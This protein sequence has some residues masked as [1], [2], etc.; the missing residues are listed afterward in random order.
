LERNEMPALRIGQAL[1]AFIGVCLVGSFGRNRSRLWDEESKR[2]RV[3]LC[4]W[5]A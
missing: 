5:Q 4:G 2:G 1:E 3:P